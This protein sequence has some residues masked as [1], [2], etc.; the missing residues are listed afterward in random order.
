MTDVPLPDSRAGS[1]FPKPKADRLK[2][3]HH[4]QHDNPATVARGPDVLKSALDGSLV[5]VLPGTEREISL[6]VGTA[7]FSISC[8]TFLTSR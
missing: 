5:V 4:H 2:D 1:Q 6:L 7:A 3:I 8:M